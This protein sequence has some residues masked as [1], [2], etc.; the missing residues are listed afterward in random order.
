MR[1]SFRTAKIAA[2]LCA[3]LATLSGLGQAAAA[4]ASATVTATSP[5][6]QTDSNAA[7]SRAN[8]TEKTLTRATVAK[9][10]YLRSVA[11]P[12]N[13]QDDCASTSPVVTPVLTGGDLYAMTN[14]QL[15]K[16]DAATGKLIWRVVPDP[17]F[18]GIYRA[19]AVAHGLVVV[20][21]LTCDSVSDPN[22][23]VL[24]FNATTGAPAW[25]KPTTPEG[26]ALDQMVVSGSDV[27]A[28]G[29]SPGSGNVV[30]VRKIATGA[31]IWHRVTNGCAPGTVLVV[32]QL[33]V[34][35]RC[36]Q[37]DNATL[38]ANKLTTGA[39][40]W[41]LA[42]N[43]GLQRGD[44]DTTAARHLFVTNPQGTVV[45]LN[46]LTGK[47]QY[48]LAGATGVLAVD[49]TRA[50][51][52]C[53]GLGVCAYAATSGKRSWH[54]QPGFVPASAAEAGGVL[55]L[56]QGIALNAGTGQTLATVWAGTASSF[57]VGDGRIA[58]VT[59]P[60]VLDLFGL[61]GS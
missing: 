13:K 29:T 17:T 10:Q 25:S 32:A 34:S 14:G 56:D 37:N 30:A 31:A 27:I 8:L 7:Q 58:V 46:P 48:S 43:W 42:G 53:G 28:A 24:A 15:S 16:Y 61:P 60:R 35:Y 22:G 52:N 18:N 36:S 6:S 49:A 9:V 5:W 26:G 39:Q 47:V 20:G 57:A 2:A 45:A 41:H 21:Q 50:Y 55:Y 38:S 33:V 44:S 59:D 3:S 11:S 54:V 23:F 1:A 4:T 12:L 19:L 40:V 51:A